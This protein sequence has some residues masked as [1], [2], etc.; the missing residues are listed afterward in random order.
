MFTCSIFVTNSYFFFPKETIIRK[1]RKA[2]WSSRP[3][4]ASPSLM[5][6]PAQPSLSPSRSPPEKPSPGAWAPT[7]SLVMRTTKTR[8]LQRSSSANSWRLEKSSW[9][10]VVAN[11]H[12][13]WPGIS[14]LKKERRDT[15][16]P[17]FCSWRPKENNHYLHSGKIKRNNAESDWVG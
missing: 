12:S 8:G 9:L 11:T 5:W 10:V 7:A 13:F 2:R 14:N 6:A 3:W 4:R 1:T 16:M 17:F 15:L